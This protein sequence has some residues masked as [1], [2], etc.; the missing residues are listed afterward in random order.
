MGIT[1]DRLLDAFDGPFEKL[2]G[3]VR[4]PA[5]SVAQLQGAAGYLLSHQ[6][7]DAFI[8][9]NR[10]LKAGDEIYWTRATLTANGRSFPAGTM[11]VPARASTL[12]VLQQLAAEKGLNFY[13]VSSRPAGEMMK[14][15]PVRIGLWDTYGGSMAS[16]WTRWLLEQYEFPFK[17]VFP[18][19]LDAGD[20]AS[21]F[22]VLIFVDGAIP[23][24]EGG[25]GQP[26]AASI[27]AE[28]RDQLGV[29]TISRTVP[30]LRKFVEAGGTLLAIGSST[31]VGYH[32]G[33]PIKNALLERST[34]TVT[35]TP[36]P[37]QKFYVPGA[38]LDARV[39][40]TNPLA[41]GLE[42]RANIFFDGSPAFHLLPEA[43]LRGMKVVAWIDTPQ[44]LRSGWA[45]GQQY[46]DQAAEIV[47]GPL[48][49]GRVVL[50]GPEIAWRAQPHGTFKFLFNGIYARH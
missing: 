46:L 35:E 39:D 27:P 12:P 48:G 16:G 10:L 36:L 13:A 38:I 23:L 4:P 41:Y 43:S 31:S 2:P 40:N 30:E 22:D 3:V 24:R 6:I 14:I 20:L 11:F 44:P 5:G 15:N 1:F 49:K 42:T 19:A 29:V 21:Q 9:V 7:N 37:I 34:A 17:V 28:F 8:A 18:K 50:F 26:S 47:E 33:L 45:W 32:F 25:G